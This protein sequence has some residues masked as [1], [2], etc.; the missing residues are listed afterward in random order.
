MSPLSFVVPSLNQLQFLE[1]ATP[2]VLV[3]DSPQIEL[4]VADSLSIDGSL[5]LLMQ[6]NAEIGD[7][8]R[9]TSLQDGGGADVLNDAIAQGHGDVVGWLNSYDFYTQG[10]VAR[11]TAHF[12]KHSN[13]K[14]VYGDFDFA[15]PMHDSAPAPS[16]GARRHAHGGQRAGR[17]R[18]TLVSHHKV[19]FSLDELQRELNCYV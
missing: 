14:I 12:P 18:C 5:D 10:A 1:A 4:I 2:S 17:S 9:W 15:C 16:S 6:L 8:L 11:A 19:Y 3:Q 13:P 7:R